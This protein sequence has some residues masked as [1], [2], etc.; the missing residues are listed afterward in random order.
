MAIGHALKRLTGRDTALYNRR[1]LRCLGCKKS[2]LLNKGEG[3]KPSPFFTMHRKK[4]WQLPTGVPLGRGSSGPRI[5]LALSVKGFHFVRRM[6]SHIYSK[7]S[8]PSWPQ[9]VGCVGGVNQTKHWF[10]LGTG[11]GWPACRA[12]QACCTQETEPTQLRA[13]QRPGRP[14]HCTSDRP[15]LC[16]H[17]GDP[18]NLLPAASSWRTEVTQ[19]L[20]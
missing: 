5:T 19:A 6:C 16:S 8:T 18:N 4:N 15:E 10:P 12:R 11:G 9:P 13:E 1:D 7:H 2:N 3:I 17:L 14:Q 20:P